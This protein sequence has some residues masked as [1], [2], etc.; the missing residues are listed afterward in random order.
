MKSTGWK[1]GLGAGMAALAAFLLL[2]AMTGGPAGAP[3]QDEW[4]GYGGGAE[5][6]H[7]S[8]LRQITR[9]NVGKLEV[10][11]TYDTGD[12][13]DGSEMQCN[14]IVIGG[15]MY[16]T[17]PKMRV[18]ALD[19]ATGKER[20]RFDPNEGQRVLGKPRN[21]GVTYWAGGGEE[22][23][24]FGFKNWLYALDA[25]TGLPVKSFG[26]A[27]RIDLREG[28]GREAKDLSVGLTTPGVVYKDLL[29]VGSIVSETL[30]AAPGHIR[31][32]DLRTGG[33]RWIFHTIPRPGEF[34]YDTWPKDAWQ[35]IG[36]ANDW[37]GMA[38]DE[39]RGLIFAPTGSATYDFYGANRHGD[40]LFANSLLCLD[41][42]T[43]KRKWHFQTIRHDLW[44]RDLPSAPALVTI[45]RNGRLVDAVAQITKSG[46]VFVFERETGNSV[47]PVE[48]RKVSTAGVDGEKLADTQPLPVLPPP[49]A[50]QVMTEE[51]LTRR[52][53]EAHAAA[54]ERFRKLRSVGQFDP[55]GMQGSIVLPGFDGGPGWGGAAFDPES[56]LF[57]VNS[58][59]VPCILRLVERPKPKAQPGG[60]NVYD[61]NCASCHGADLKGS[62]PEFPALTALSRKYD[63]ADLR[64]MIRN[65]SGRMPG[66]AALGNEALQAVT[67]YLLTGEDVKIAGAGGTASPIEQKYAMDGYNRFLDSEGYPAITPPWGTLSAIDL[68][69]GAIAWQIPL[70]EHPELAA[71][72][73]RDT[74]SWNYGGPIVTAG[75]VV[76]IAA[77]NYDKKMRAFDKAT[78]KLL[79]ESVLPAAG[80]ATPSTYQAGGRQFVVIAAGGGKRGGESGGKYVAFALPRT[81]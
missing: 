36:G 80:N 4:P 74:G 20:W 39:K 76:F 41:A 1:I 44:D 50:R 43:G 45:R 73:L 19:A 42:A 37:S 75:G 26:E 13:F 8:S 38:L 31:A 79:W 10:A 12:V 34:G 33:Q 22:R 11:W 30:P 46:H 17:S 21:R 5:N 69:K 48:Y 61:R 3:N 40:N 14:P 32:Y 29:I 2:P 70:G 47:F 52:T 78:G 62:P 55:P 64:S 49:I 27:G 77:T 23:L 81:R 24:Y 25:R 28:L 71:K 53:P 16:G 35:Y 60:R 9:E 57:F 63:E 54:L 66:F 65:G 68:N 72:G 7:F 59:E 18:F 15:V 51:M 6:T 67:R 58:S 56:G